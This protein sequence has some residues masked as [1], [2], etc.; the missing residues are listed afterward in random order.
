M[1]QATLQI[2]I[3]VSSA[4]NLLCILLLLFR[5]EGGEN[6]DEVKSDITILN[7]NFFSVK[8]EL[9]ELREDIQSVGSLI[10]QQCIDGGQDEIGSYL[11][12][13]M[14]YQDIAKATNR[15][16]KEIDLMLKLRGNR[17]S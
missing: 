1:N 12:K 14:S 6:M 9:G 4:I 11:K 2:I 5:K 16:V 13:G 3:G 7:R 8:K 15:S 17:P 10:Q